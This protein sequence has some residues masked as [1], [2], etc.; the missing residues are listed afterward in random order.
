MWAHG[1]PNHVDMVPGGKSTE[2]KGAR[3][4]GGSGEREGE[5]D[6]KDHVH[7]DSGEPGLDAHVHDL[8]V[9][10][11]AIRAARAVDRERYDGLHRLLFSGWEF[12]VGSEGRETEGVVRV[13]VYENR[14]MY[15]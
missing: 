15:V 13:H 3:P 8:Q 9:R 4:S 7:R 2:L 5:G 14:C 1:S 10:S 12:S 6:M 11:V